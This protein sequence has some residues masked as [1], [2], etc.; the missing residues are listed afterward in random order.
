MSD[1]VAKDSKKGGVLLLAPMAART[2]RREPIMMMLRQDV[3]AVVWLCE[4]TRLLE[5]KELNEQ[6]KAGSDLYSDNSTLITC[7]WF[8]LNPGSGWYSYSRIFH[9]GAAYPIVFPGK[10]NHNLEY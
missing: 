6:E 7:N 2:D 1:S 5:E 3:K 8:S 10:P 9:E 4:E